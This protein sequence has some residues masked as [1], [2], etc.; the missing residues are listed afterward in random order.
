[1][2]ICNISIGFN[3]FCINL[4]IYFKINLAY[5]KMVL[6][7]YT[8]QLFLFGHLGRALKVTELNPRIRK[9][10]PPFFLFKRRSCES[11]STTPHWTVLSHCT[12]YLLSALAH[13]WTCPPLLVASH[14]DACWHEEYHYKK[15]HAQFEVQGT[16]RPTSSEFGS[17]CQTLWSTG[18]QQQ[19]KDDLRSSEIVENSQKM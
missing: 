6:Y 4:Y 17:K 15:E 5:I 19:K 9:A 3:L 7:P 1:M 16:I 11:I 8:N 14:H 10:P 13:F 18:R 2:V 12:P